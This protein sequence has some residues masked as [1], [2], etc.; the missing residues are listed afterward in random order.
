MESEFLSQCLKLYQV[1]RIRLKK[2]LAVRF[3]RLDTLSHIPAAYWVRLKHSL[4][5]P[6]L[7]DFISTKRESW[8]MEWVEILVCSELASSLG[9]N[10]TFENMM[11]RIC[12]VLDAA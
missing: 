4:G 9:E 3:C 10:R 11:A 5:S 1:N 8:H 7:G 6:L 2:S 12:T